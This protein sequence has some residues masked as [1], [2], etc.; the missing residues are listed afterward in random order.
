MNAT[1]ARSLGHPAYWAIAFTLAMAATGYAERYWDIGRTGA[2]IGMALAS[3]LLIP[4]IKSVKRRADEKGVSSPAMDA[5]NRR[6]MVWTFGYMVALTIS[7]TMHQ[8]MEI[9]GP[10]LWLAGIL[11][12]LPVFGMI[13]TMGRYLREEQDEY[14]RMRAASAAL[15]ATGILLAIA[16]AWGFLEMFGVVP[17][18]P[19]WAAFPIWAIGLGAGQWLLGRRA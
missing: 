11:P 8:K 13:W 16:T 19:S 18:V 14:L 1:T 12:S 17:H 3:L 5:Y 2:I 6:F 10:L 4:M 15:V 7:I 9:T